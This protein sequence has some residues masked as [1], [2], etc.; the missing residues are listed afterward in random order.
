[1]TNTSTASSFNKCPCSESS[2]AEIPKGKSVK[3]HLTA[4]ASTIVMWFPVLSLCLCN[5][6]FIVEDKHKGPQREQAAQA[7]CCK[8]H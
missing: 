8:T 3:Q 6:S 5:V 2:T 1:M 7:S 4:L